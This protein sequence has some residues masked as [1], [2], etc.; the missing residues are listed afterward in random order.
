MGMSWLSTRPIPS[1]VDDGGPCDPQAPNIP[2]GSRPPSPGRSP[3][4]SAGCMRRPHTCLNPPGGWLGERSIRRPRLPGASSRSSGCWARR[5]M[6]ARSLMWS[7][8]FPEGRGERK[9]DPRGPAPGGPNWNG[10]AG[11]GHQ[12]EGLREAR[13]GGM[14][15]RHTLAQTGRVGFFPAQRAWTTAARDGRCARSFEERSE[16]ARGPPMCRWASRPWRTRS[17]RR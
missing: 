4:R 13:D 7:P 8:P 12:E 6:R 5:Q 11:G 9:R 14:R 17:S 1:A 3:R 10:L 16:S 2:K 15:D